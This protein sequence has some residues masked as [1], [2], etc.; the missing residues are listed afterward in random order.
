MHSTTVSILVPCM[1][2]GAVCTQCCGERRQYLRSGTYMLSGILIMCT[3][4]SSSLMLNLKVPCPLIDKPPCIPCTDC[5]VPRMRSSNWSGQVPIVTEAKELMPMV[6]ESVS[7]H[8]VGRSFDCPSWT[9]MRSSGEYLDV[10]TYGGG[11]ERS[12]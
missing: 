4:P 9:D 1:F 6:K 11:R 12:A 3:M 2:S 7:R 5:P 10:G 8:I